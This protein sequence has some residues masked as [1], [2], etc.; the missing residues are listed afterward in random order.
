MVQSQFFFDIIHR[1]DGKL[2][3]KST[4][5]VEQ[6][7]TAMNQDELLNALKKE[8]KVTRY[9]SVIVATLLVFVIV[10]GIYIVNEISPALTALQEMQP[11]IEKIEQLDV[12]VLNEKIEELDI[13]G[14]NQVVK[15]LDA[16]ALSETL[17][18]MNDAVT[19]LKEAGEGFSEF[20]DSVSNSFSGLFGIGNSN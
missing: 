5:N 6:K 20:S 1:N 18:N 14:L 13:E 9:I 17:K 15:D 7:G 4:I 12:E 8:L 2:F 11:A 3:E 19:L 10:C 16:E